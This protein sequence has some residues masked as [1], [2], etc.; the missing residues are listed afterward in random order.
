MSQITT[1]NLARVAMATHIYV[2]VPFADGDSE[3]DILRRA[4]EV[5]ASAEAQAEYLEL[6]EGFETAHGATVYPV[7][8]PDTFDISIVGASIE[9]IQS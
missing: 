9:D 1:P 2:S 3:D 4:A 7:R 5:I 8:D 6:A